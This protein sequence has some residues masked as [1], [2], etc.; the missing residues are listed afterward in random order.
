MTS[1]GTC[2]SSCTTYVPTL[3]P[4]PLLQHGGQVE[5]GASFHPI[6][7]AEAYV[8]YSPVK[9]LLLVVNGAQRWNMPTGDT[10]IKATQGDVAVGGYGTF[11]NNRWYLGGLAGYGGAQSFY[12]FYVP[13]SPLKEYRSRYA[14]PYGQ[15]WLARQ[16]TGLA[17]GAALRATSLHFTRL[18]FN[19]QPVQ[20]SVPHLYA[21]PS[22]FVRWGQGAVQGHAQVGVSTPLGSAF[23]GR[24]TDLYASELVLGV[25]VVFS[26]HLRRPKAQ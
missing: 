8:A 12:R 15:L 11:G 19:D 16:T 14:R 24:E 18:T 10:R 25:G 7:Q 3:T 5:A 20:Q 6:S 1:L 26:P 2:I 13:D 9:H 4:T 21:A 23:S 22:L 17:Y